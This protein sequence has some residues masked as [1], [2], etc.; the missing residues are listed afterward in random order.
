MDFPSSTEIE[1]NGGVYLIVRPATEWLSA[2]QPV[3][4][5]DWQNRE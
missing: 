1:E 2:I 4:G 3:F 5:K